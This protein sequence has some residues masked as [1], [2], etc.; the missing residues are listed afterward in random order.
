MKSQEWETPQNKILF[1]DCFKIMPTLPEESID[2]I[3]TD[4]PY[5]IANKNKLTKVSGEITS[6]KEAWGNDFLDNYTDMQFLQFM[7]DCS[8]NFYRLLK[9]GGSVIIFYDRGKPFFLKPFYDKF[10]LKN[11]FAFVK[12][13]P[14]PHFRKNNYRSGY[15][16]AMWFSKGTPKT[17]NF[18]NQY[19]MINVFVG[20]IGQ[21]ETSHPTEKPNWMIKPL[22]L[23]HSDPG[24]VI[25]DP[26]SGSGTI[27]KYAKYFDREYIGIEK[28]KEFYDMSVKRVNGIID[29]YQDEKEEW[30]ECGLIPAPEE[31][32]S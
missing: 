32:E 22:I 19:E 26:F 31:E 27:C 13:N 29:I 14:I 12:Q 8:D 16:Q 23:R 24:Q 17:F 6:N 15:E 30:V 21:K 11:V 10:T 4:P 7:Q 3:L 20:N 9:P 18:I 5:N 2:L 25:M 1:G 28:E